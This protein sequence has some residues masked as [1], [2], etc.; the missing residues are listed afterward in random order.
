MG[1][2]AIV[3]GGAQLQTTQKSVLKVDLKEND[4]YPS[5]EIFCEV[6]YIDLR[7]LFN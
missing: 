5:D 6:D 2:V 1:I 7:Q 3:G 4:Q